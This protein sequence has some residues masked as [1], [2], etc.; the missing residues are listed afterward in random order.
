MLQDLII[1]FSLHYLPNGRLRKENFKLL[2]LKVFAVIYQRW[3]LKRGSNDKMIWLGNVWYFL[4][5]G[6][7]GE[8]V[9]YESW[10]QPEVPL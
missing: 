4:K 3:S 2:A 1:H 7:W 8:V 10:T 9:A 6:R 5:T